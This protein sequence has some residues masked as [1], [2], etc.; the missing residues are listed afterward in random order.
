MSPRGPGLEVGRREVRG[1]KWGR[2]GPGWL[3]RLGL[4][5][6]VSARV[7]DLM[8]R[9][10]EPGVGLQTDIMEPAWDFLSLSLSAPPLLNLSL[11]LSK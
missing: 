3:S 1:L 4:P 7:H 2:G 10:F 6:L 11:S 8:V 5:I 9:E